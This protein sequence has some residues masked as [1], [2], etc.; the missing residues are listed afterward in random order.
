ME[1]K[2]ENIWRRHLKSLRWGKPPP[3]PSEREV[4]KEYK[5]GIW[6][7]LTFGWMGD[8]MSVCIPIDLPR[9]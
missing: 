2:K 5:A 7:Q 6:K 3:I 9:H 4:T 1:A 8:H